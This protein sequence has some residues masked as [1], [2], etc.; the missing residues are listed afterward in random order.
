ML[1]SAQKILYG[2][3]EDL[4]K[5]WGEVCPLIIVDSKHILS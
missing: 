3:D 2:R 4:E 1:D 5:R